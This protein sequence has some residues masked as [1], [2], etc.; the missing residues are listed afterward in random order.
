MSCFEPILRCAVCWLRIGGAPECS[1]VTSSTSCWRGGW[2]LHARKSLSALLDQILPTVAV[3]ADVPAAEVALSM[4]A[5]GDTGSKDLLVEYGGGGY[6]TLPVWLALREVSEGYSGQLGISEAS[7]RRFRALV[8]SS[9]DIVLLVDPVGTVLYVSPSAEQVLGRDPDEQRGRNAFENVHPDDLEH[10]GLLLKR[11]LVSP[12][13]EFTA[14]FRLRVADGEWRRFDLSGRNLLDDPDVGAIVVNFRDVTERRALEDELRHQAF[15]DQLTGLPNRQAF[16]V[17]ART[18]MAKIGRSGFHVGVLLLDL[19]GFKSANDRFGHHGGDEVLI[20]VAERVRSVLRGGDILARLGGDEFAILVESPT[21]ADIAALAGRVVDALARP[22]TT[23]M[24]PVLA[25]ASIGVAVL[26]SSDLEVEE[27]LRRA[28]LAMYA[29]KAAGKNRWM[30]W[31]SQMQHHAA[32]RGA[33]AA[34]LHRAL[35]ADELVL[36]YQPI[37]D[38]NSGVLI[39]VEALVRWQEPTL[40]LLHPAAFIGVAEESGLI[41]ALGEW[42]LVAAC[43]ESRIWRNRFPLVVPMRM[44][45]NVSPIQ[46][47]DPGF[48][49]LVAS[50]LDRTGVDPSTLELEITEDAVVRDTATAMR[51]LRELKGL[52]LRLAIDDFGTG[53]SSLS[54]LRQFPVDTLKIDRSF[55]ARLDEHP[56]DRVMVENMIALGHALNLE[57]TAEGVEESGQLAYLR[58][59]HCD[60]AQGYHFARPSPPEL[61][62][63]WFTAGHHE[64]QDVPARSIAEPESMRPQGR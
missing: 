51:T 16:S 64:A 30:S 60:R 57:V 52:G 38:V 11:A 7:E 32:G 39:G 23:P 55:I 56:A 58:A 6:G 24:A 17:H 18:A 61:L 34:D 53:H 26:Q 25:Q 13:V 48:A 22:V 14:E 21:A 20:A 40:G 12:G 33:T 31:S 47:L 43:A 50:V 4:I 62:E 42:V 49:D 1:T 2:A 29:C 28:D 54:H 63:P 45:V 44:A 19:D 35:A 36:H 3:A 15:H 46:L 5:A 8:Q 37:V 27:L 10:L 41:T 59:L 9:S